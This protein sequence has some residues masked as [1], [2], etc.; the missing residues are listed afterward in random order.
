MNTITAAI[1][2]GESKL[3]HMALD[4]A[5]DFAPITDEEIAV[6]KEKAKENAPLFRLT[7]A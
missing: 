7:A 2:P 1:P 5:E 4:I 6:L 3:F